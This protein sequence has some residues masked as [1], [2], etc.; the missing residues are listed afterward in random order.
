MGKCKNPIV[1]QYTGLDSQ[2]VFCV[3][4]TQK[5]AAHSR[6]GMSLSARVRAS[7]Q[8][9]KASAFRVLTQ[10]DSRR[11]DPDLR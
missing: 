3:Y 1:V 11:C 4:W 7:G 9:A 10:A 8:R 5:E 6:K 2:L